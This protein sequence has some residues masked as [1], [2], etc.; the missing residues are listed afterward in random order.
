MPKDVDPA[1]AAATAIQAVLL[2]LPMFLATRP[3]VWFQ[4]TEAQFAIRGIT[5]Q[6]TQYF[7]LLTALDPIVTKRMVGDVASAPVDN[8][9]SYLKRKANGGVW[10]HRRPEG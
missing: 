1:V 9:Y 2:E 6:T 3:N 10:P 7:Y 5:E 4:Q 8:K